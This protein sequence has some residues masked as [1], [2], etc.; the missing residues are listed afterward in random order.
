MVIL[1][2]REMLAKAHLI[3][4]HSMRKNIVRIRGAELRIIEK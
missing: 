2:T 3:I 4:V 1:V